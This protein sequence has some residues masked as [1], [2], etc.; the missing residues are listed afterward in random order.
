MTNK[1]SNKTDSSTVTDKP[2]GNI[3]LL[4]RLRLR[5]WLKRWREPLLIFLAMRLALALGSFFAQI[6]LPM[7]PREALAPYQAPTMDRVSERLLGVMTH[8]DGEWYLQIAQHGYDA[9]NG[10]VAFFPLYPILVKIAA[11]PLGWNYL[12]SAV[13][14]SSVATLACLILLY[15]L[16]Q[17]EWGGSVATKATLYLAVFPVSFFLIADYSESLFLALTLGV[18]LAARFFRCWWLAALLAALATLTRSSGFLLI[19]PL[20]WEW[21]QNGYEPKM[22]LKVRWSWEQVKASWSHRNKWTVLWLVLPLLALAAWVG[23]NGLIL[24]DP[25]SF[26]KVQSNWIWNRHTSPPWQTVRDGAQKFWAA[27]KVPAF[28]YGRNGNASLWEFPFFFFAAV[29]FL[30]GSWLT[31]RRKLPLSYWLYF[32]LGLIFPLF[33]PSRNEPLLSFPRFALILFP[34]YIILALLARRWHWLHYLY[35]YAA[36][37]LLGLFFARFANWYWVA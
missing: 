30:I 13:I 10:T 8:W 22:R 33:S 6:L 3:S 31:W 25:L 24:G 21:W 11:L 34:M 27:W 9:K 20:A 7:I 37:L 16:C 29:V 28:F 14:V 36:L 15:E 18:F 32:A 4:A 19:V 35:L 12:W 26:F 2:S 17:R 23:Y 1:L 5:H